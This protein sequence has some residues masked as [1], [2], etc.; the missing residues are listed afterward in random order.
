MK[1]SVCIEMIFN[2]L[3]FEQRLK[4]VKNSGLSTAEIWGWAHYDTEMIKRALDESEMVLSSMCVDTRDSSLKAEYGKR[5]LLCKDSGKYFLEVAKESVKTAKALGVQN[6]IVTTGQQR[7]DA[8]RDEQHANIVLALR[9]AAPV[10]EDAGI[11]CVLE[12]LNV[13]HD[14]IGYFLFSS[15]EAFGIIREVDNSSVKL[16]FDVYHQQ[17]SEGNLIPNIRDNIGLIGHFHIADNPGRNEPGTGEINYKNVFNAIREGGY[18]RY[19][20]LEYVPVKPPEETLAE[21]I[22]LLTI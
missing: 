22:K 17:I 12:P 3:P 16:L 1:L 9:E 19:I 13:L 11:T 7:T 18:S 8:T 5:G 6:L 10:F 15:Y 4:A 20:G 21:V 2:K 14:H